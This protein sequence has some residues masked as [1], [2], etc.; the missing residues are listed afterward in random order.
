MF[1]RP[2]SEDRQATGLGLGTNRG[3]EVRP[4]GVLSKIRPLR[5]AADDGPNELSDADA[6]IT[7]N[8]ATAVTY[9]AVAVSIIDDAARADDVSVA[10]ATLA[11]A[12]TAA[13]TAA[14]V[15]ADVLASC[16]CC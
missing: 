7:A 4:G 11:A 3:C 2:G 5:V 9:A 8:R 13:A 16:C 15:Y 10:V 12:A 6:P 14:D 1:V